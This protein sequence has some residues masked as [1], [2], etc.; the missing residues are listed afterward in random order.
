MLIQCTLGSVSWTMSV[1]NTIRSV[2]SG[3]NG[4]VEST[5]MLSSFE[6]VLRR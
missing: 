2:L 3:E 5:K 4:A 6:L 1:V